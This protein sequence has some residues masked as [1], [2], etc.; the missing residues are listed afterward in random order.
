MPIAITALY[1]L[2]HAGDHC[3]RHGDQCYDFT[4]SALLAGLYERD[5][6]DKMVQHAAGIAL[7]VGRLLFAG[8]LW[9]HDGRSPV[10]R[11]WNGAHM[12]TTALLPM[13]DI[14]Q[15]W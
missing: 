12:G 13:L 11:K 5:G 8:P 2:R 4:V 14:L 9:L 7:I 10:G 6:G 3:R 15:F 1:I